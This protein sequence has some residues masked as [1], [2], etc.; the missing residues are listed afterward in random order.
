[1]SGA[2][3]EGVQQRPV[4]LVES[5]WGSFFQDLPVLLRYIFRQ[6]QFPVPVQVIEPVLLPGRV[7]LAFPG[8]VVPAP[9]DSLLAVG[10]SR[11]PIGLTT[12]VAGRLCGHREPNSVTHRRSPELAPARSSMNRLRLGR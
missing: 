10:T 5:L 4:H 8:A 1:M 2:Q 11:T 6:D 7:N 3:G 12:D 9:A